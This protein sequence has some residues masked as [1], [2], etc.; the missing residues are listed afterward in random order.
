LKKNIRKNNY[1]VF[2]VLYIIKIRAFVANILFRVDPKIQK[3]L[4]FAQTHKRKTMI[5]NQESELHFAPVDMPGAQNVQMR[6]LIGP[7]DGSNDIIMRHFSIAQSGETPRHSH[8]YEHVVRIVRN[9]GIFHDAQGQKHE[10]A[11]GQS[12]FVAPNETHQFLNPNAEPFEFLCIIPN[13][14]RNKCC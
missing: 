11:E 10:V 1:H 2:K 8:D 4:K 7:R 12:L 3:N 14:E 13:P 6:I 9:R 5:I